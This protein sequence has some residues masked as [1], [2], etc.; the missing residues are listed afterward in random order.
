M[1]LV[2]RMTL[3]NA[4]MLF[5]LLAVFTT[6]FVLALIYETAQTRELQLKESIKTIEKQLNDEENLSQE[7]FESIHLKKSIQ[8]AVFNAERHCL[9]TTV[10][11]LKLPTTLD[12]MTAAI[13]FNGEDPL[14]EQSE[15]YEYTIASGQ[16]VSYLNVPLFVYV[17]KDVTEEMEI[18][19]N[20]PLLAGVTLAIGLVLS[21]FAGRLVS[22][23]VLKP[24]SRMSSQMQVISAS[25]LSERLP[26]THSSDELEELATSFN[27]MIERLEQSFDRQK[28]FVSDASHELRTP[29]AVMKGHTS[30]LL[31]WGKDDPAVVQDSLQTLQSEIRG[32][33][34]L[35]DQLLMLARNDDASVKLHRE[36]IPVCPF[37]QET[38]DEIL[39]IHPDARVDIHCGASSV[40]ADRPALQQVLRILLDNSIKFCPPPALSHSLRSL[41]RVGF[42]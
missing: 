18:V 40:Y 14:G 37:L 7:S 22:R 1:P 20:I 31:R 2:W 9:Y 26:E 3:I 33:T 28:Q 6:G 35:I 27:H 24:V 10:D 21:F 5:I 34:N 4:A 23:R 25:N 13:Q 29:L 39:M 38:A 42:F 41:I 12:A 16:W 17:F 15:D 11:S 8:F 19:E 30:M 36:N 32:M